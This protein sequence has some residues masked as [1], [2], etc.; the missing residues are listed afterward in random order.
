MEL[1]N[2]GIGNVTVMLSNTSEPTYCPKTG[3][4]PESVRRHQSQ[5]VVPIKTGR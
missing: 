5:R 4:Y 3:K 2:Q 1:E